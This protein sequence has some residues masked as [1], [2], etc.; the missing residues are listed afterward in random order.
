MMVWRLVLSSWTFPGPLRLFSIRNLLRNFELWW[1]INNIWTGFVPSCLVK[2]CVLAEMVSAVDL[3][4][5]RCVPRGA[6]FG[7][8][9]FLV[10][11]NFV[12]DGIVSSYSAFA[13][14]C[15]PYLQHQHHSPPASG[16]MEIH[17][18]NL[19]TVHSVASS[20]NFALNSAKCDVMRF[21]RF[22]RLGVLGG[23]FS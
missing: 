12:T 7:R 5:V 16:A 8:I 9:F 1:F 17:W 3:V 21:S 13:G 10:Y 18:R 2:P 23:G 15:K 4:V 20:W 6:V 11:V 14:Y 22:L 19:Y